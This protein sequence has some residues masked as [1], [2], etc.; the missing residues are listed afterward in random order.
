[1]LW[2]FF[3]GA[4]TW[5]KDLVMGSTHPLND[6]LL[7]DETIYVEWVKIRHLFWEN[8]KYKDEKLNIYLFTYKISWA[9]NRWRHTIEVRLSQYLDRRMSDPSKIGFYSVTKWY[10]VDW[11][12]Y[13]EWV[14]IKHLFWENEK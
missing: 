14:K 5:E 6:T 4:M 2:L 9:V 3:E 7:V 8:E 11:W 13:F 1:M 12:I 10:S